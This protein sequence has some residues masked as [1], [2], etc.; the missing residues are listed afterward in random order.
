MENKVFFVGNNLDGCYYYRCLLPLKYNQWNG[1]KIDIANDNKSLEQQAKE[2]LASD[3]IVFHRPADENRLEL[4]RLFNK[5]G[6][7]TVFDNDDTFKYNDGMKFGEYFDK[8]SSQIDSAIKECKYVTTT[9]EFLAQEYR[10]L[11]KNVFVLPNQ[12]DP[13][14]VS[15]VRKNSDSKVRIGI[16]G[17]SATANNDYTVIEPLLKELSKR[18]D[19]TLVIFGMPLL[20]KG[21]RDVVY[22]YKQEFEFWGQFDIEWH[23]FVAM[24]EYFN[25]LNDLRLDISLIPRTDNYFNRAKSNLK[26]LE[27]SLLE[28]PVVAQGFSDGLSPYEPDKKYLSLAYTIEDWFSMTQELIDSK[29]KRVEQGKR[30]REYV[31]KNYNIHKNY[32]S[33]HDIYKQFK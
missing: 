27:S 6:K 7:I 23:P 22:K 5:I 4:I 11:N 9:T 21:N 3:I 25:T 12:I 18:E 8:I 33:W 17:S 31:L 20:C 29:K 32:K 28:I 2:A 30:A 14:V 15:R 26:F 10:Q 16:F 13:T 1:S 24:S 19:V